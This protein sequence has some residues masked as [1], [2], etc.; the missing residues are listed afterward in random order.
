MAAWRGGSVRVLGEGGRRRPEPR[1]SSAQPAAA[2]GRRSLGVV[3]GFPFPRSVLSLCLGS[4]LPHRVA[5]RSDRADGGYRTLSSRPLARQATLV[6]AVRIPAGLKGLHN[7]SLNRITS[8]NPRCVPSEEQSFAG[9][10]SLTHSFIH[11]ILLSSYSGPG[12]KDSR[13]ANGPQSPSSQSSQDTH[14]SCLLS[15][16]L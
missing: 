16:S 6:T 5:A 10:C 12:I 8:P 14:T 7:P 1:P 9:G 2:T 11:S 4:R 15:W 13:R 3:E